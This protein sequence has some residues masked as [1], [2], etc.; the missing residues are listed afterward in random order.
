[1]E[2][3]KRFKMYAIKDMKGLNTILPIINQYSSDSE[4][5]AFA[6]NTPYQELVNV[7]LPD[8]EGVSPDGSFKN[9]VYFVQTYHPSSIGR[10]ALSASILQYIESKKNDYDMD[11]LSIKTSVIN[12]Y[13]SSVFMLRVY[14]LQVTA[15]G[16]K[17]WPNFSDIFAYIG[18]EGRFDGWD[19][20]SYSRLIIPENAYNH[21]T[22]DEVQTHK[23]VVSYQQQEYNA[24]SDIPF[25]NRMTS[26]EPEDMPEINDKIDYVYDLK[27][28]DMKLDTRLPYEK[29]I[30]IFNTCMKYITEVEKDSY[31][32]VLREGEDKLKTFNTSIEAYIERTYIETGLLPK[33]DY[34][35]LK[36]KLHNAL[37]EMYLLQDLINDEDIS[38]IKITAYDSIRVRIRGKAYLSNI[39]F[40]DEEDFL[41][42]INGIAIKNN[43]N[44]KVPTQTFTDDSDPNYILRFAL[45]APYIT[46]SGMPIMH[47]RKVPRHKKLGDDLIR[48][49]M[50]DEKI[51]NYLLDCGKRSRGVVFAG[52]PGSGKTT[53]MNWFLEEAYES[54]AEILVIQ[55]N[56]E[57][58]TSR[59]GVIFE[60]IVDNPQ[61]GEKPCSLEELGKLALVSGANVFIIGE[62]K[63]AEICSAITLSNSGCRTAITIH[64]PSSTETLDKMAD[65]A[66]RGYATSYEQAKR[67]MKSFQTIVFLQDFKVQEISE[68]VGYDEEKKD[69]IYKPIYRR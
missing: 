48:E 1:M 19:E 51:K 66:M 3:K 58:F 43:I 13:L 11:I 57:L 64:S 65:L 67:M 2:P 6:K 50:F 59:K 55:E 33:E 4:L 53:I 17:E 35:L 34:H 24:E 23:M 69:M 46:S 30:E 26:Y 45:T 20:E 10:K 39:T 27:T 32:N 21:Y 42:F 18:D 36:E 28:L 38:D 37:F 16:K 61:K 41:R 62:A 49:G 7:V 22:Y 12:S 15:D 31:Y 14:N 44:L 8:R 68:I 56:D 47:I 29:F 54:S 5:V 40:I 9:D 60:H 52:P 25:L 63:G